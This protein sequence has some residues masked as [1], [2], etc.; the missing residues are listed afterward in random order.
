MIKIGLLGC[1]NIGSY[2]ARAVDSGKVRGSL[3]SVYDKD[4]S[5]ARYLASRLKRKPRVCSAFDE[6]L[7]ADVIVEAA[8]Q[9]AVRD[10]ALK[11]LSSGKDVVVMSS[12]ALLDKKLFNDM[13]S[14]ARRNNVRIYVPSGALCG[15]DGVKAASMGK[16]RSVLLQTTKPP[17]SIPEYISVKKRKVIF[18]GPA[19]RAVKLFPA[20]INISAVL[21]L[22]GIGAGKTSV[23]IIVDPKARRNTHEVFL[24]G[25]A[26]KLYSRV[27]NVPSPTN[28]RTSYL[29]CLSAIKMLNEL[30]DIVKIGT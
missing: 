5:K 24:E 4:C 9:K 30:N 14:A 20:N 22:A 18:N 26:G 21:S 3:I 28:P 7:G 11:A 15:I 13:L 25:D 2:I 17:T 1:G 6:L 12:G 16:I 23:K 10:F 19:S 27:E 8:S 29:A